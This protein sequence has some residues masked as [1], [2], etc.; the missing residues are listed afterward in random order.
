[1]R[2]RRD[3]IIV[4]VL[5]LLALVGVV[6]PPLWLFLCPGVLL[7]FLRPRRPTYCSDLL[8][9]VSG[10]SLGFW[11]VSF[12]WL[13]YAQVALLTWAYV[14]IAF[15][16]VL[17]GVLAW[18]QRN[19]IAVTCDRQEALVLFL[20]GA[21]MILRLSLYWREPF[22]PAGAD[23]SM[24][25]YIA[26]LIVHYNG[27]PP[28]HH[29][30]LPIDGF[31][32]YA[33]GFHTLT[34]L[35]SL[36]GGM[37]VYR[38]A[39]LMETI[40]FGLLSAA[41]Y[42]FL[43]TV[44]DRQVSVIVALIV[45]FL[46]RDPQNYVS[47]GGIPT[48]LA[49][50]FVVIGLALLWRVCAGTSASYWWVCSF[51]LVAGFLTH[52]IPAISALYTLV[53]IAAYWGVK[54][55]WGTAD[56]IKPMVRPLLGIA[57]SSAILLAPYL[58]DLI[59]TEVSAMEI[60]WVQDWQRVRSGGAWGGTLADAIITV[61][62]YLRQK[63]YGTP[64][65]GLSALGFLA[66]AISRS[67]LLLPSVAFALTVVGLVINSMY[68]VLPLSYALYPERV[69]LLLL[70]PVGLGIGAL[71]D[72]LR[73]QLGRFLRWEFIIGGMAGLVLVLSVHQN[74]Q[75]YYDTARQYALV[76]GAD[77]Q[78]LQWLQANTGPHD[79]IQ[80]SYGDAGLWIPAIAFRAITTPHLNPFYLDELG[81]G[82]RTLRAQY[83]Y[84]GARRVYGEPIDPAQFDAHPER[85]RRVYAHDGVTIYRIMAQSAPVSV[86]LADIQAQVLEPSREALSVAIRPEKPH[87][88]RHDVLKLRLDLWDVSEPHR[89][90]YYLVVTGPDG[91]WSFYDGWGLS[92]AHDSATWRPMA[93]SVGISQEGLSNYPLLSLPLHDLPSGRYTLYL[94]LTEPE[95]RIILAKATATFTLASD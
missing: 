40:T 30:L 91:R 48:I 16:M 19:R 58:P 15:S 51:F 60:Q 25:G 10:T 77:L 3:L 70:L 7:L 74:E 76:T 33:A 55:V 75:V 52:A 34:A 28:S 1:M 78:A 66:L 35:I 17:I 86:N 71:I 36:L 31:G 20:L 12:W 69:A 44:W 38:S 50:V 63:I 49:L 72:G 89:V 62:S 9:L 24:H 27:V 8:V 68:W 53:S 54:M 45:T 21:A 13:K 42:L 73:D 14:V 57:L 90:D 83:V 64:F 5:L 2:C 18:K 79:V 56:T 46:P 65:L 32:G 84:L 92:F 87:Y 6:W 81:K 39:L 23:M 95:S 85:Y 37:P 82:I 43:R 29:P 59:A 67:P 26:A 11:V 22:A 88:R 41:I 47:W 80:A 4:A 94:W 61:P 93:Q